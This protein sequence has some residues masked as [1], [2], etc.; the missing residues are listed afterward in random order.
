MSGAS[1]SIS[2][3]LPLFN[4]SSLA[5]KFPSN[6]LSANKLV[7]SAD[8][9]IDAVSLLV[10]NEPPKKQQRYMKAPFAQQ[11][12][13]VRKPPMTLIHA[14]KQKAPTRKQKRKVVSTTAYLD[15]RLLL[16]REPVSSGSS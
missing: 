16:L 15:G 13:R 10:N 6:S 14:C 9:E 1:P 5:G 11:R 2:G 8:A 12:H 3:C 4:T 7:P